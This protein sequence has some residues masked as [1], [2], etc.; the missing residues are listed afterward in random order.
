MLA[1]KAPFVGHCGEECEWENGG[2]CYECQRTLWNSIKGGQFAFN[3]K[4]WSHISDEAKDLVS[5][6]L[7]KNAPK[8]LTAKEV[9]QHPWVSEVSGTPLSFAE[10]LLRFLISYWSPG[11]SFC[12]HC[13]LYL[14]QKTSVHS[15]RV[16]ASGDILNLTFSLFF[17]KGV[18]GVNYCY[19]V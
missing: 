14:V 10:T 17:G 16:I 11:Y 7:V 2:A 4:E 3:D 6:L 9:L 1:G 18:F 15:L 8:R 12:L 13:L 5:K 19:R